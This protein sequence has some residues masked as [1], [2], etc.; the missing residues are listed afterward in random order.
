MLQFEAQR[1]NFR[2]VSWRKPV[3]I[4]DLYR[5]IDSIDRIYFYLSTFGA[6]GVN[7]PSENGV[8]TVPLHKHIPHVWFKLVAESQ[9]LDCPSR[10]FRR[11]FHGML[12]RLVEQ[13]GFDA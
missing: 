4:E 1:N 10:Q 6:A 2:P 5:H 11:L 7:E 12:G 8:V 13:R 3:A 9:L